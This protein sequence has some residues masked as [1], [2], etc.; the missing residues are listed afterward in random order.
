MGRAI[1]DHWYGR[2][3]PGDAAFREWWAR[4]GRPIELGPLFKEVERF[5]R[6]VTDESEDGPPFSVDCYLFLVGNLAVFGEDKPH[7]VSGLLGV[8]KP[9]SPSLGQPKLRRQRNRRYL[10][11]LLIESSD[12]RAA[13]DRGDAAEVG[14]LLARAGLALIR[15]PPAEEKYGRDRP[16][17]LARKARRTCLRPGCGL[18]IP[19]RRRSGLCPKHY[20]EHRRRMKAE[21]ERRRRDDRSRDRPSFGSD[22]EPADS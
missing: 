9:G 15:D 18:V 11:T 8:V 13:L 17:Y 5:R 4:R 21:S 16:A 3:N 14:L 6:W 10:R 20:G 7:P 22:F 2:F 19:N 1:R 12:L